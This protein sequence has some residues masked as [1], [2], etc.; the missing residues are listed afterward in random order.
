MQGLHLENNKVKK[1]EKDMEMDG[2]L[3]PHVIRLS[4][5]KRFQTGFIL[6]LYQTGADIANNINAANYLHLQI[7]TAC[8]VRS[9][10]IK[11]I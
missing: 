2:C 7:T 8:S 5:W 6:S 4:W 9:N 1:N 3:S 10:K 11:I